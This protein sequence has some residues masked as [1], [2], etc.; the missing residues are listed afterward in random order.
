M[1]LAKNFPLSRNASAVLGIF[2]YLSGN[3][4]WAEESANTENLPTAVVWYMEMAKSGDA[5]AQ[6]NLGSVYE[7]G[8]GVKADPDEAVRWY[9][10]AA[11]QDHQLAQLKL[12]IMYILGDGTR[13]SAIKGTSLIRSAADN[14]NKFAET[15]YEKVLSPDVV[16]DLSSEEIIKKIRPF[17]DLGEKK[18][19]NKLTAILNK[20]KQ[21]ASKKEPELAERFTGKSKNT[22]GDEIEIA[23]DVPEF[24]ENKK[25]TVIDLRDSNLALLQ[26]EANAGNSEAQFQLGRMYDSGDKLERDRQKAITWYTSAANQGHAE[27]QY[28]LAIAYLYGIGVTRNAANGENWLTK[29]AQQNHVVAKDMLPI[30]LANRSA[31]QSTSIVLSWYLEK[32][33]A[34]D[35]EGQFGIGNMYESG[36]G[37]FTNSAEAKKWYAA[38]RAT[39]S[40]GAARRMR[41]M[42]A[43]S[44][45]MDPDPSPESRPKM[46]EKVSPPVV[47]APVVERRS[48]ENFAQTNIAPASNEPIRNAEQPRRLSQSVSEERESSSPSTFTAT[49]TRR[50]PLTPVILIVFGV[51]MGITVFKWMRRG[52]YKSSAF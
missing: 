17:I 34:G 15:L 43:V 37:I 26:R 2:L 36:W 23:N 27:S 20:D 13:Q 49:V 7:T 25:K 19:I 12:G 38:A 18:S 45:S 39:G 42:K 46:P 22:L 16:R 9:K 11:D 1:K 4:A 52:A 24:I 44:A 50:S 41:Q 35:P 32:A 51:V 47:S 10:E 6:Y 33:A 30:Y 3:F 40:G 28:R 31:N 14:G 21:K 29:A 8:F 5:D 48:N